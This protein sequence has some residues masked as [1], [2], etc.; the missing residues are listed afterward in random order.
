[1]HEKNSFDYTGFDFT[2]MQPYKNGIWNEPDS[3]VGISLLMYYGY[4][5][6]QND[7]YKDAAIQTMAYINSEYTGSSM[8]EILL[9]FGPM[10]AAKYNSE[11]G[12][13]F[14]TNRIFNAVFN[15]NSI[16]RGGWGMLNDNYNG[17]AVSG[18][19]GSITD[20]GGYAF[21][22]NTFCISVYYG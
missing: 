13:N 4:K 15:G 16:P 12:T 8:Y 20:G 21:S 11:F 19:M 6:T 18:L 10:L 3:A 9:Y 17:F 5:L 2:A 22:M 7:K 1:M 14:D